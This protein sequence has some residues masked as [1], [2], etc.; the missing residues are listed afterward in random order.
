MFK[1]TTM[2]I[3]LLYVTHPDKKHA[4][5]LSKKLIDEHLIACANI[6]PIQ[7]HFIWEGTLAEDGE[8]VSILKTHPQLVPKLRARIAE[9]HSYE[10]PCILSW[11]VEA[12]PS[13]AQWIVRCVQPALKSP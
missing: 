12:N 5:T 9:L 10:V 2:Q 3:S 1:S 6:F 8:Y 11:Q 4:E 13:Y 7:S